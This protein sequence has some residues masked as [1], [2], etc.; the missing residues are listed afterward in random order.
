MTARRPDA[1]FAALGDPTRRKLLE[2]VAAD[3]PVT[4]TE[5]TRQLP[6]SRQAIAKHLGVLRGAGLVDAERLGRETR[7]TATPGPLSEVSAWVDRVGAEWD[8]RLGRLTD[9]VDGTT[10]PRR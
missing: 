4:A 7:F 1:V 3:G 9:V 5:L 6:I 2:T 8:R 10:R